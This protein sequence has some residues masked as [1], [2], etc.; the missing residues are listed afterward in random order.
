MK[1]TAN[2]EILEKVLLSIVTS[3]C[4]GMIKEYIHDHKDDIIL[5]IKILEAHFAYKLR[6]DSEKL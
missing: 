2:N 4:A 1:M 3:V 5:Q 6:K